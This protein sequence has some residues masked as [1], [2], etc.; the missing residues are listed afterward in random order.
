MLF[1][2]KSIWFYLQHICWITK[3]IICVSLPNVYNNFLILIKKDA[4]LT[5]HFSKYCKSYF[6]I[7]D[8]TCD[9]GC[10]YTISEAAFP[11]F[12]NTGGSRVP[13]LVKMYELSNQL[14]KLPVKQFTWLSCNFQ[15]KLMICS[16]VSWTIEKII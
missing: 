5:I 16:E 7:M 3:I 2:V 12:W 9:Y 4:V 11:I 14:Q 8:I 13:L 10:T 15:L 1:I 6:T